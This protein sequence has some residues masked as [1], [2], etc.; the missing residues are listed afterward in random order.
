MISRQHLNSA[1]LTACSGSATDEP[2]DRG[3]VT[4]T[5]GGMPKATDTAALAPDSRA[6]LAEAKAA[7][8]SGV[9]EIYTF[10]PVEG[11]TW[12]AELIGEPFDGQVELNPAEDVAVLPYSSGTTALPKGV[13][14]THRNLVANVMQVQPGVD[15]GEGEVVIAVLPFFH[16]YG[17]Q[18]L[19]NNLLA[20][21]LTIVTMP[22][23]DLDQFLGVIE[24][25]RVTEVRLRR[26]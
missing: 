16:I 13:M 25:H 22:R 3:S 11:A 6:E 4:L 14:L 23:F 24:E 12:V 5:V 18:V 7:E 19:M 15:M 8:T 20:E 2:T 17:M 10:D 26:A 9:T 1:S 21:G